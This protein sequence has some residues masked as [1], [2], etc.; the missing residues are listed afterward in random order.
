MKTQMLFN[1]H[2]YRWQMIDINTYTHLNTYTRTQIS[3][4]TYEDIYMHI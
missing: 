4:Y 2:D 1:S 3:I